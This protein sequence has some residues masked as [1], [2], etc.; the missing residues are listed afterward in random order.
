MCFRIAWFLLAAALLSRGQTACPPTP[1]YSPCDI[2]FELSAEEMAAH[3][4]PYATVE[5]AAEFRSPRFHTFSM[6]AFWDGGNRMLIR[7]AP[8]E[9]GDWSFQVASNIA[10]FDGKQGQ[11]SA[12][13]SD[14]H[15]F[16]SPANLHH[17]AFVD[18]NV[19]TPHLWMGDTLYP[20]PFLDRA[21]FEQIVG[22]RAS[23]KFNHIRGVLL[24]KP[25]QPPRPFSSAGQPDPSVFREIDGRVRY[26]NGKGIIADLVLAW[27]GDQVQKL[28]PSWKQ[29]ERFIRYLVARY[30]AMQVTWQLVEEFES[31]EDGRALLKE[32][33]QMLKKLDPYRHPRSTGALATSSPLAGD[34]WMNFIACGSPDDQLGAIEHQLHAAS[35]VNLRLGSEDSAADAFRHRLWNASMNG[36]YPTAALPGDAQNLDSPAAKQMTAWFDFFSRT[37]HWELEPYFDVDG[38]RAL[39]LE[40][41]DEDE[42]EGI[43]YVVYI[44]KPGPVEVLV[45][46]RGYDVA[47][48]N[49]ITG[50]YQKQ[51][52]GFKGDRFTGQPPDNTHDWVL[53]IFRE[54][55]L[56]SMLRSYKFESRPIAMQEIETLPQRVPFEV[57]EPVTDPISVSKPPGYAVKLSRETRATR[58]MMWLW[59]GEVASDQQGVRVL[60]TGPKGTFHIPA[61]IATT[62]PATLTVRLYGM[63]A[64]GKVYSLIKVYQLVK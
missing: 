18:D 27:S 48:F 52:K 33:G 5:L 10:R 14:S 47:W 12:T 3:P 51:K 56:E 41:P 24:S 29:R 30:S 17:W 62:Y 11:F 32:L 58:S 26:M 55:R 36:Q 1:A 34:E 37:R 4:N 46:K 2:A 28:F 35:F 61:N 54:G 59:T 44:E 31:A 6:P 45:Q 50:D 39:A 19:R 13:A 64:N 7:F 63:N 25:D 21:L 49:P 57:V 42:I 22:A 15:G 8:T 43:E 53:H 16:L 60:G 20:F 38:G 23:Q 9:A 40:R